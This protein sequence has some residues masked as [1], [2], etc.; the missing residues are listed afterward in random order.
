MEPVKAICE[1]AWKAYQAYNRLNEN[2]ADA[3]VTSARLQSVTSLC[4]L[5][6]SSGPKKLWEGLEEDLGALRE[7]V[8]YAQEI[9]AAALPL[10][11]SAGWAA[12]AW[13]GCVRF[14][15]AANIHEHLLEVNRRLSNGVAQLAAK[16][17]VKSASRMEDVM[18]T[19]SRMERALA[20]GR[21][22]EGCDVAAVAAAFRLDAAQLAAAIHG[23]FEKM[24]RGLAAVERH[25]L[26]VGAKVDEVLRILAGG[27]AGAAPH[28]VVGNIPP[29][30][31]TFERNK[32]GD[33]IVLGRGGFGTVYKA[34]FCGAPV[35]VKSVFRPVAGPDLEKWP[36]TVEAFWREAELQYNLRD[37][38]VLFV[39]GAA[40]F[41][42]DGGAVEELALVMKIAEG[43]TLANW[44]AGEGR[45]ATAGVRTRMVSRRP[46]TLPHLIAVNHLERPTHLPPP[47]SSLQVLDVARGLAYLHAPGRDV[48]HADVKPANV[49]LDEA[50]RAMLADLG[51]ARVRRPADAA[52]RTTGGP[53]GTPLYMAPELR[54][55]GRLTPA[56]DV[57]SF[58]LLAWEVLTLGDAMEA[59]ISGG[60][61]KEDALVKLYRRVDAGARPDAARVG[62][63]ALAALLARAWAADP[64]ARPSAV[65]LCG[66]LQRAL[67]GSTSN[68]ARARAA[69]ALEEERARDAELKAA[70]K[71]L[72]AGWSAHWDAK[73]GRVFY[74]KE[75]GDS[76][77]ERPAVAKMSMH[78]G[79]GGGGGGGGGGAGELAAA[80]RDMSV[81]ELKAALAARGVPIAGLAEKE[82]LRRALVEARGGGGGD[83][84]G[85]AAV[86]AAAAMGGWG[87]GGGEFQIFVKSTTGETTCL[88]VRSSDTIEL[89]K[90]K[91]QDKMGIPA[92]QQRFIFEGRHL[93]DGRT[94]SDC[95]VH[96]NSL[97]YV[98]LRLRGQIGVFVRPGDVCEKLG[99]PVT[100]V[101]GVALL[102]R[103]GGAA[104]PP[105]AAVAALAAAVLAPTARAPRGDVYQGD[106]EV[107]PPA[108]RAALIAAVEAS[109]GTGAPSG[110]DGAFAEVAGS[111]AAA[112]A[113]G[114]AGGSSREDFRMLVGA[115]TVAHALG[116]GGVAAVLGA[117]EAVRRAPPG[118]PPLALAHVVFALRRT[119]AQRE[120][121]WIGFHADPTGLTA[122]VPLGGE[123]VGGKTVFALPC[124]RLL[125]PERA[126]GAVLAHHGDVAHGVTALEKGLRYGLYALVARADAERGC[127]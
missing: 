32:R 118:A 69:A 2:C 19:L 86:K 16:L 105:P 71:G 4:R 13:S 33:K 27:G 56:C 52:R 90:A 28:R 104:P 108:A 99:V 88:D 115:A 57:F 58:G 125:V 74:A 97:L 7:A 53:R 55:G 60:D 110:V 78:G 76:Q 98:V 48:V 20:E 12:A 112:E 3:G 66:E 62:D 122:Q 41:L 79:A 39:H 37:D 123:T 44:L 121:K 1:L 31:L 43:G 107:A 49:L 72:P 89:V 46:H 67:E 75:G 65:D 14:F 109:W 93:V 10:P 30:A 18:D 54:H 29:D 95:D 92:D 116:E 38:R 11:K 77:W 6:G 96:M 59:I 85:A 117:L 36:S 23:D 8:A 126:V 24:Q 120:A 94:L 50:G 111:P 102:R 64:V 80:P 45:A 21:A 81:K 68:A 70:Q 51:I 87:G 127:S 22:A 100:R 25:V 73:S 26:G 103:G 63:P 15:R 40:E 91:Y 119:E 84:G 42:D 82:D 83:G 61:D 124:G 17:A 113:V 106:E 114:V 5:V 34:A 35:A 47:P 101:P 9:A